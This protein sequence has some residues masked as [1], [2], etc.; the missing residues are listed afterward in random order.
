MGIGKRFF[1]SVSAFVN[2]RSPKAIE[3]IEWIPDDRLLIESDQDNVS[4]IDD[5]L[6]AAALLIGQ[7]K[8][9]DMN[10][11]VTQTTT[12]SNSFLTQKG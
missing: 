3:R 2:S 10:A 8:H 5:A 6:E 12:N 11:T 7:A 1:F 9:W 4:Q